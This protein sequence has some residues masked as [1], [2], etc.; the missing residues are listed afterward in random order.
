MSQY[1]WLYRDMSQY[2]HGYIDMSQYRWL[3]RIYIEYKTMVI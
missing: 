3:Y 1:R 2:N